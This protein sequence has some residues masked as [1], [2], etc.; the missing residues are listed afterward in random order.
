MSRGTYEA[1]KQREKRVLY[2]PYSCPKCGKISL[3]IKIEKGEKKVSAIC[4]CGFTS[5]LGYMPAFD[6]V[7]YYNQ[8]VDRS[9]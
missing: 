6:P 8:L 9:G 4:P 3:S 1:T 2:G 7:D 5:E